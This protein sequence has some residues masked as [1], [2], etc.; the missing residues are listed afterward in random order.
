MFKRD[1]FRVV[2]KNPVCYTDSGMMTAVVPVRKLRL[3]NV[4]QRTDC[5][6]IGWAYGRDALVCLRYGDLITT[7][8]KFSVGRKNGH[9]FQHVRFLNVQKVQ[10]ENG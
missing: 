3:E 2:T 8:I 1:Y 7:E 6:L 4:G 5:E 9:L 10:I